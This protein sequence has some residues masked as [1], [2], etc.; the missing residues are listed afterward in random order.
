MSGSCTEFTLF[1]SELPNVIFK[2][3][4]EFI[5]LKYTPALLAKCIY[6]NRGK[7]WLK[8]LIRSCGDFF[9]LDFLTMIKNCP[10]NGLFL[11]IT[12]HDY[13]PQFAHKSAAVPQL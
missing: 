8:Q 4:V 2:M 1:L 3:H 12:L 5:D 13:Y 6:K 10:I 7:L 11:A 9:T